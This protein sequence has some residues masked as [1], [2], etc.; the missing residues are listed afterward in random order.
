MGRGLT[1]SLL[2]EKESKKGNVRGSASYY[3]TIFG[4][5]MSKSRT[6]A[7]E[8]WGAR[9]PTS[10]EMHWLPSDMLDTQAE[11]ARVLED[12]RYIVRSF[13]FFFLKSSIRC[14]L[15][16]TSLWVLGFLGK[17]L[18]DTYCEKD[19]QTKTEA[20]CLQ[21][22]RTTGGPILKPDQKLSPLRSNQ[23]AGRLLQL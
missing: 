18:R 2:K 3:T 10:G 19:R 4:S 20:C 1:L 15:T 16:C 11:W 21:P 17:G 13:L 5:L 12:R 9:G 7:G 8:S 6:S 23:L 22:E 14:L